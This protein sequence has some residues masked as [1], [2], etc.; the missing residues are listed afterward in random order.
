VSMVFKESFPPIYYDRDDRF[1]G[2]VLGSSSHSEDHEN[3]EPKFLN[4]GTEPIA[5]VSN[6]EI[7]PI[8]SAQILVTAE[9]KEEEVVTDVD[10]ILD[11]IALS[12]QHPTDIESRLGITFEKNTKSLQVRGLRKL[13]KDTLQTKGVIDI[14]FPVYNVPRGQLHQSPDLKMDQNAERTARLLKNQILLAIPQTTL[15]FN[16][17]SPARKEDKRLGKNKAADQFCSDYMVQLRLQRTDAVVPSDATAVPYIFA[18]QIAYEATS[19][20]EMSLDD[21]TAQVIRNITRSLSRSASSHD[22]TMR[23]TT[24]VLSQ[25]YNFFIRNISE[26]QSAQKIVTDS[27]DT[28]EN[29]E[30]MRST[31]YLSSQQTAEKVAAIITESGQGL[32]SAVARQN[33]K[34][35]FNSKVKK[36]ALSDWVVEVTFDGTKK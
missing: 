35:D 36:G 15:Q 33:A 11:S 24:I 19:N 21:R 18:N 17:L 7:D 5:P 27:F 13:A 28:Y 6:E 29:E 8:L 9:N 26:A 32:I 23:T 30:G 34:F 25:S 31:N 2:G 12:L 3:E 4:E 14:F 22:K 20:P 10:R 1:S 16:I